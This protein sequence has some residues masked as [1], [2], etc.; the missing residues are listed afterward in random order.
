[1]CLNRWIPSTSLDELC[2]RIASLLAYKSYTMDERVSL[3]PAACEQRRDGA[4]TGVHERIRR[5]RRALFP[6]TV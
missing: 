3:D 6:A 5:Q 2:R 4:R 1:M